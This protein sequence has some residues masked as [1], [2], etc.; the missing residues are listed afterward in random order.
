MLYCTPSSKHLVDNIDLPKGSC[1]IKQFSDGEWHV[2]IHDDVHNKNVWVL[3]QTGA[4]ADNLVQLLLLLDALKREGAYINILITYFGYARQDRPFKGEAL[5]SEVMCKLLTLCSP[6]RIDVIH[7]HNPKICIDTDPL[8]IL[9]NLF[10][11]HAVLTNHI[12]YEFFYDCV[13]DAEIIVSPDKGARSLAK[14]IAQH[15][16]KE[17]VMFEKHRPAPEQLTLKILGDVRGKRVLIVDDM[18]TTGGTIIKAAQ[19]LYDHGAH[20]VRVAATHGLFAGNAIK[21]LEESSIEQIYVT[22]T[23]KQS[24]LS[25]KITV[26]DITPFIQKIV[27]N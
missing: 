4:P 26:A 25:K 19:L 13:K 16:N 21:H 2:T 10:K 17:L 12:P 24:K 23:L 18:I 27:N 7:I 9:L 14:Q 5:A 22:D 1:T 11:K 6:Q 15:T 8:K 20:S 3:A